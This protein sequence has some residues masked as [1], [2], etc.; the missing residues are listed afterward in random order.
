[1]TFTEKDKEWKIE[2]RKKKG[3]T[4]RH[5]NHINRLKNTIDFI[6]EDFNLIRVVRSRGEMKIKVKDF[7]H[8]L[9]WS[10]KKLRSKAEYVLFLSEVEAKL[11][12]DFDKLKNYKFK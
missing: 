11:N 7:Y 1:M 8:T 4:Y 5:S 12:N 3:I 10:S 6:N 2:F 9:G